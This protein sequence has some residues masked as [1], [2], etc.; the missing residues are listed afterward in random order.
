MPI[1]VLL[2]AL[3]LT[4]STIWSARLAAGSVA[5]FLLGLYVLTIAQIVVVSLALSPLD[6][7]GRGGYL[8]ALG[9][10]CGGSLASLLVRPLSLPPVRAAAGHAARGLA[11]PVVAALAVFVVVELVYA[12]VLGTLTPSTDDDALLYHLQ[13]AA[14]WLQDGRV[15]HLDRGEDVRLSAFPP[16]AELV[17]AFLMS[18]WGGDRPVAWANL[19]AP[20]ALATAVGTIAR[21]IGLGVR[22][23]LFGALVVAS[24]PVIALQASSTLTD[25][26][27]AALVTAAAAL[28]LR[29]RV[30]ELGLAATAA[31]LAL[32]TKVTG[33]VGLVPLAVLAL[34]AWWPRWRPP[35]VAGVAASALGAYWFGVNAV[36]TGDP[37]GDYPESERGGADPVVTLAR[38]TRQAVN[39][40]DVPGAV[41]ADRLVFVVVALVLGGALLAF[42]TRL[43]ASRRD[44]VV[45]G[46]LVAATPL[47]LELGDLALRAHQ[48]TWF[49]LGRPELGVVDQDRDDALASA[50]QAGAGVA[51]LALA[52]AAV[53]VVTRSVRRGAL[54]RIALGL[55][56]APFAWFLLISIAVTYFRWNGRFLLPGF[57][58]AAGT[59]GVLLARR[60][61][62]WAV[63]GVVLAS[64]PLLWTHSL[65]KPLGLELLEPNPTSS[66]LTRPRCEAMA[67]REGMA[68]VV[69]AIARAVPPDARIATFPYFFPEEA[70][71]PSPAQELMLFSLFG[72]ELRR[73][74]RYARTP[75]EAAASGAGWFVAPTDELPAGCVDGWSVAFRSAEPGWTLLRLDPAEQCAA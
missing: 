21:R 68:P 73:E 58:I 24:F 17:S 42:G 25:L 14:L 57:A 49:T 28:L 36:T 47:V 4:T 9:L 8:V 75:A 55:A 41:G 40:L 30:P 29:R 74:V 18:G 44:A 54:P 63:V 43:G 38:V 71:D 5:T 67:L 31:G 1:L 48:K 23:A 52:L 51:G 45:A 27:V 65:E 59:W 35:V 3:A 2:L 39:L 34:W 6:A 64:L 16:N 61:L 69:C 66:V 62:A 72:S 12:A 15:S 7:L 32:G 20:L 56:L 46:V 10:L 26:Q 70:R 19:A 60:W 11:D 50:M 13:R 53:V 37:L 22:E 33:I